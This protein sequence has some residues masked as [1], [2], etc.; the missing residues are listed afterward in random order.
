MSER[1]AA[2]AAPT[3]PPDSKLAAA[4][5]ERAERRFEATQ[6]QPGAR[7]AADDHRRA[8]QVGDRGGARQLHRDAELQQELVEERP[9]RRLPFARRLQ[10][11]LTYRHDRSAERKGP[12]GIESGA[13]AAS[14]DYWQLR[15]LRSCLDQCDG[16][17]N[18]PIAEQLPDGR[19]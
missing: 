6:L 15:R 9:Q 13:N 18:A 8:P 4:P 11:G 1:I 16:R 12:R 17:R 7:L 3:E 10:E 2:S 5:C 14:G 19:G